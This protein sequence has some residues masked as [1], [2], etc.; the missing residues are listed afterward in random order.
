MLVSYHEYSP[1]QMLRIP[2]CRLFL[3][4][5]DYDEELGNVNAPTQVLNAVPET[6]FSAVRNSAF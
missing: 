2:E 4:G 6:F 1:V 5:D 3:F